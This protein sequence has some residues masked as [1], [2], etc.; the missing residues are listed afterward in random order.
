MIV[1][2]IKKEIEVTHTFTILQY[3]VAFFVL[4]TVVSVMFPV[5]FYVE[6]ALAASSLGWVLS[7]I[8]NDAFN[9]NE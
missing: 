4:L 8:F 9:T 7:I 5:V 6:L 2:R 1:H 3:V